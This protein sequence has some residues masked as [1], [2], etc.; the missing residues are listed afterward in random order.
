MSE[1]LID[2]NGTERHTDAY[3]CLLDNLQGG[4]ARPS[5]AILCIYRT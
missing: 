5:S 4:V 3:V 2:V 1:R